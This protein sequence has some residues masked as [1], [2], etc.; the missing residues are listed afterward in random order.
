MAGLDS[1]TDGF[2]YDNLG[3]VL[4]AAKSDDLY[5]TIVNAP[6]KYKV[7][8]TFLF[9]GIVVLL[10]VNKE[11]GTIDRVAL[12]Q[13]EL[14][15]NT[16][17]VSVVPFNEIKIPADHND[18]IIAKAIQTG[19]PQ[20]TTD[21]KF[22]FVPALTPDQARINQAS[23]GIA[24]SAVYPLDVAEGGAL[25]FSY[26]Q[27]LQGI[28]EQQNEFMKTYSQLVTERLKN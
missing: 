6:F 2:D 10:L 15:K 24:Y 13:T 17:D 27:Y 11:T 22:L 25:I 18:N 7:E 28:G 5:Q 1:T 20:D 8:T 3:R 14:A 21:W 4:A 12:S 26:F 23:G 19:T 16:T 9:L